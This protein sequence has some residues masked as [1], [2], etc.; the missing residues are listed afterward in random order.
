MEKVIEI[1]T[2]VLIFIVIMLICSVIDRFLRKK[3]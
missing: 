1:I 3:K 2:M